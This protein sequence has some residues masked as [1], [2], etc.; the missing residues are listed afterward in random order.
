MR[1]VLIDDNDDIRFLMRFQL[2]MIGLSVVGE[3]ANGLEGIEVVRRE[4]PDLVVMDMAM[5]GLDGVD[6][7]YAIKVGT[8]QTTVVAFTSTTDRRSITHILEAGAEVHFD[9]M[10]WQSVIDWIGDRAR[11]HSRSSAS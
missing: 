7:T 11:Q 1:I 10:R 8:P 3:G 2:E 4:Q 9:K 5:P 6:T